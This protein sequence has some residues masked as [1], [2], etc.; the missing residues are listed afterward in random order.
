MIYPIGEEIRHC[1]KQ[2]LVFVSNTATQYYCLGLPT[3][4]WMR[5][6]AHEQEW[7]EV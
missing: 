7:F 1:I 2:Q 3:E 6:G 4:S 5:S